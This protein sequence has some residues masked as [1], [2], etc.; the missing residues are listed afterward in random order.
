MADFTAQVFQNEYLADGATDVHAVVSV[1]VRQRRRRRPGPARVRRR[2]SSSS[3]PSGLDGVAVAAQIRGRPRRCPGRDLDEIVDGTLVRVIV[4][5]HTAGAG[6]IPS[7][8]HGAH[9]RRAPANERSSRY[10][11]LNASGGTA[12]GTW[13]RAGDPAVP[14]RARPRSA[15]LILLTDGKNES[16]EPWRLGQAIEAARACS[17]A[18]RA[19]SAPTGWSRSC[20]RSPPALMGSVDLI[21]DPDE[22]EADFASMIRSAMSRGVATA[23]LRVWALQGRA[24]AVRAPGRARRWRT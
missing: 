13:L 17:S 5:R 18:T 20:V 21:A 1:D 24:G 15:T 6:P 10:A 7:R 14:R 9:G 23:T 2:R 4:G 11:V 22:M 12:I 8:R 3:T 16:E 19:A